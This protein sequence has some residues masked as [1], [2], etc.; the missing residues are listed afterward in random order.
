MQ[1]P[2]SSQT[3]YIPGKPILAGLIA[4]I[5]AGSSL[6][7]WQVRREA[8]EDVIERLLLEQRRD[9]IELEIA[10][11]RAAAE[12]ER[13]FLGKQ[14]AFVISFNALFYVGEDG[15]KQ[16]WDLKKAKLTARLWDKLYRDPAYLTGEKK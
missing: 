1:L 7:A 12:G 9:Q 4:A 3:L 14:Q 2:N 6:L 13:Q 10:R 8:P 11:K 15:I 5:V 16:P